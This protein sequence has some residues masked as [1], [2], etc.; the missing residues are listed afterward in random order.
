MTT[1][2]MMNFRHRRD[3]ARML[4]AMTNNIALANFT[5]M[6]GNRAALANRTRPPA[7][8]HRGPEPRPDGLRFPPGERFQQETLHRRRALKSVVIWAFCRLTLLL[9]AHEGEIRGNRP[10]SPLF[11]E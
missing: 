2:V 5:T 9:S 6:Q 1:A 8:V 7:L 11:H 4:L 3:A 10:Y